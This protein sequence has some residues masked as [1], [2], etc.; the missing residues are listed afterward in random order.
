MG[1]VEFFD[2]MEEDEEG[3][4]GVEEGVVPVAIGDEELESRGEAE[5]IAKAAELVGVGIGVDLAGELEGI[6]PRAEGMA[7]E[8]I[9][10]AF[11]GS[12]GVSD[13]GAIAEVGL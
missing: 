2:D 12:V 6:E 7:G 1:E 13:D 11:F 4:G 10:K 9:Q 5:V 3:G 8:G